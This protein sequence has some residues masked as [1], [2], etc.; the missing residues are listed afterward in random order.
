MVVLV[1]DSWN[2]V[3]V[4]YD[5]ESE[6]P[7]VIQQTVVDCLSDEQEELLQHT[8]V[9]NSGYVNFRFPASEEANGVVISI[10]GVLKR[11]V[12]N[13][14]MMREDD[15]S[16]PLPIREAR[17]YSEEDGVRELTREEITKL[18]AFHR[19]D[20]N[21]NAPYSRFEMVNGKKYF[22]LETDYGTYL[23]NE[24]QH[25]SMWWYSENNGRSLDDI[26]GVKGIME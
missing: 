6:D 13:S 22:F 14:E 18:N 20:I 11:T 8:W 15:N 5:P 3:R 19:Y 2:E 26:L 7:E 9:D 23:L 25:K 12:Y 21:T 4:S 17:N 24:Q 10:R 1:K 16:G